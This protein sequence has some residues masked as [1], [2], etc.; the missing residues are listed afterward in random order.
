MDI[1]ISKIMMVGRVITEGGLE[2]FVIGI[3]SK[4]L[5]T[6]RFWVAFAKLCINFCLFLTNIIL[7]LSWRRYDNIILKHTRAF[8]TDS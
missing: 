5:V 6:I 8:C 1:N 4:F 7:E 3:F 2:T